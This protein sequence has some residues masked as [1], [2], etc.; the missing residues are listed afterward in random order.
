MTAES[1]RPTWF[2]HFPGDRRPRILA[3]D[4]EPLNL[5][6]LQ[7]ALGS[8]HQLFAALDGVQALQLAERC[9]PDLVLLDLELPGLDGK[10]VCRGLRESLSEQA[11][12]VIFVTA[13]R[14]LDEETACW[15]A[16]CVDFISKP[17]NPITLAN[18]VRAQLAL[19][20]QADRLRDLALRD[21]LTGIANRRRFEQCLDAEWRRA[22]RFGRPLGVLLLDVDHFKRY[23]DHYGHLQGD[24][25]LRQVA[26]RLELCFSRSGDMVA[27]YGG[28]EFV[29]LLPDSGEPESLANAQRALD[30]VRE[31]FLPHGDSPVS[32]A[33]TISVGVATK[34]HAGVL[35]SKALVD[36]ADQ[37]L[38]AAKVA[39]RNRFKAAWID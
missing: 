23:N 30:A 28:E 12:P 6:L 20:F 10:K 22:E 19:K 21:G 36:A 24:D 5:R 31:L 4:D 15:E 17:W 37:A 18:R 11:P 29:V 35:T 2:E 34:G 25:C 7:E 1:P 33:V 14:S 3:V 26:Q 16:G 39:G 38:Y 9:E 27:R 8:A 13:H 32:D